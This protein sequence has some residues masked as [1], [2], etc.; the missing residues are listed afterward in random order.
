MLI[1]IARLIT[2]LL[3]NKSIEEI[4]YS[5]RNKLAIITHN[6]NTANQILKLDILKDNN[7]ETFI[8]PSYIYRKGIIKNVPTD[9]TEQELLENIQ[10]T[11]PVDKLTIHNICRF[12]RKVKD[13]IESRP[14]TTI[15]ITYKGRVLPQHTSTEW[16][17]QLRYT[18]PRKNNVP[19]VLD[20]DTQKISAI[21]KADASTTSKPLTWIAHVLNQKKT[22][23]VLTV[24]TTIYP[25]IDHAKQLK[26]NRT[27]SKW[28]LEKSNNTRGKKQL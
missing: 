13:K 1:H 8:P 3:S 2:P 6:R 25:Q 5:G 11:S 7:L 17:T 24:T 10:L 16:N 21:L 18:F 28:L 26:L 4:K 15:M 9:I 19:I 14:T 27:S 23:C 22:S 20:T 12:Y